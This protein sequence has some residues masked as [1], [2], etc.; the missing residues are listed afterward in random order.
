M[1]IANHLRMSLSTLKG[2]W[3]L[4][5]RLIQ[6]Q[7]EFASAMLDRAASR[8][9][10]AW[11]VGDD[12]DPARAHAFLKVL[13]LHRIEYHPL[14]ETV[15]AGR[16]EF[17]PGHAWV[18]PARQRQF[19]LA[20]AIMETR[21]SFE[22][23]TFYD[24][25]AW[26]QPLAYNLPYATLGKM[27]A[28][29][30]SGQSSNGLSPD[31]EARAWVI[32]WQQMEAAP[33]L[34]KLLSA[35]IRVRTALKPFSAQTGSG[36][37]PF[38][39][40]T[41]F[42][43]AGIQDPEVL[44]IT[45][46]ILTDAALSGLD[47]H[48][49]SSTSTATGPDPGSK[50]FPIVRPIRPLII[51]GIGSSSYGVGE[52]WFV[53]DQRLKLATPIVETQ[54]LESV[55]LDDYTHLLMADGDYSALRNGIQSRVVR[56]VKEGGVLLTINRAAAWAENLCFDSEPV[57]CEADEP[58]QN[59]EEGLA[60][61]AYSDFENDRSQQIIGGAV[62]A[63]MA[64]LSHPL[65][66]GYQRP[67]LPLF[68]RGTTELRPSQNPYSTPVRYTNSPLMAGFI[69]SDNLSAIKGQPAVIAEKMGK[70]LVV[71]FANNPLFRGFWRGT[72][73]LFINALY[74]AQTVERTEI[75]AIARKAK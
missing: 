13:E 26:T 6:Y 10:R 45:I 20:E 53:L 67:E 47:V 72:E 33:L 12:A 7:A 30:E 3:E 58:D 5:D 25:S 68:R 29:A 64:D 75:P 22:D 65:T 61:R 54:H 19:G 23:E 17:T 69:G 70:G 63:S 62:V 27:P 51:G 2:S 49:L 36:L 46:E 52:Q 16:Q 35:G 71:R 24:V 43:L 9:F 60:P 32:S 73:K 1:A 37:R 48:S 59:S 31:P 41:L 40:G 18:I 42:I 11:V 74:F 4:R 34:Q 66:F 21:T 8:N 50:H 56:W 14:G 55:N 28:T 38:Q 44:P 15:R 39:A 57:N